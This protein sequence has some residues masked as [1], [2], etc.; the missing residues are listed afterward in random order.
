MLYNIANNISIYPFDFNEISRS[1]S[2]IRSF[3]YFRYFN[4]SIYEALDI[5]NFIDNSIV[6]VILCCLYNIDGI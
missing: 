4:V 6:V 5:F 1:I 2:F 3:I